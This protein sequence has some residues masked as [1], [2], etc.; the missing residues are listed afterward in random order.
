MK[1]VFVVLIGTL[2]LFVGV[3]LASPCL[4]T[5]R[6]GQECCSLLAVASLTVSL[7]ASHSL[8]SSY[9]QCC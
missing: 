2:L 4:M 6:A 7:L 8:Q 3:A 5:S 1:S 9:P